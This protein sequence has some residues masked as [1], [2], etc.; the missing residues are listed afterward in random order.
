MEKII[1][2][3]INDEVAGV[4]IY[5]NA[6][7]TWLIFTETKEWVIELTKKGTLWYNYNFFKNLFAYL[8]FDVVENLFLGNYPVEDTLQNGV[9]QTR[10]CSND[11]ICNVE[12]T[13]QNGVKHTQKLSMDWTIAVENTIKNGVKLTSPES[14][15]DSFAIEDTIQNGVKK[16][17][18]VEDGTFTSIGFEGLVENTLQNGVKHTFASNIYMYASV[19]DTLQNGVKHTYQVVDRIDLEVEDTLQNGVKHTEPGGYLGSIEMK[20]EIVHHNYL[21]K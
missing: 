19:E 5:T 2:R 15:E 1:N 6:G 21:I 18:G 10:Y 3:L 17:L 12:D 4:D 14:I 9:K 11:F 16:T 13:L 8:G 7:S 20:G